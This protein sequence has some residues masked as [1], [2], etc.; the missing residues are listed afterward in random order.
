[1]YERRPTATGCGGGNDRQGGG[2]ECTTSTR[3]R[4]HNGD[5]S[6]TDSGRV[7]EVPRQPQNETDAG[8][9]DQLQQVPETPSS[10]DDGNEGDSE[11][12]AGY[13][14][15][16][17]PGLASGHGRGDGWVTTTHT[18]DL[19]DGLEEARWTTKCTSTT[20]A[21][22]RNTPSA[23][24]GGRTKVA[25][26][27]PSSSRQEKRQRVSSLRRTG[28]AAEGHSSNNSNNNNNHNNNYYPCTSR[29]SQKT[30]VG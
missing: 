10:E 18:G 14:Y 27:S 20:P 23:C 13:H 22:A 9:T 15:S 29:P 3:L 24:G 26:T 11:G 25:T 7:G 28:I 21:A 12:Q 17:D 6:P 2:R 16:D 1:M 8:D 4:V 19:P 30:A 5:D